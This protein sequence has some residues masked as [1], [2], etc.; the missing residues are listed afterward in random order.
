MRTTEEIESAIV[1][2][3]NGGRYYVTTQLQYA[4]TMDPHNVVL[5]CNEDGEPF[6]GG[7]ALHMTPAEVRTLAAKL[8]HEADE[9]E[10]RDREKPKSQSCQLC[11]QGDALVTVTFPSGIIGVNCTRCYPETQT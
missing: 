7:H 8:L 11:H 9:A 6:K 1:Y 10:R 3:A 4:G 2:L 5:G